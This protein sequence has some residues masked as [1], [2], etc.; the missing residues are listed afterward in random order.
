VPNVKP[1]V[2]HYTDSAILAHIRT[3]LLSRYME[4]HFIILCLCVILM[5]WSD[6]L[7]EYNHSYPLHIISFTL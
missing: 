2:S 3:C 1:V 5:D 7:V 6:R 4:Y